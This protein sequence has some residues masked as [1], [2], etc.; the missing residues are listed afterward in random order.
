VDE[1]LL[2]VLLLVAVAEDAEPED[3]G[4]EDTLLIVL[5]VDVA[6]LLDVPLPP[7]GGGGGTTV[8]LLDPV[9]LFPAPDV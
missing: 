7:S 3:V 9:V 4:P 6:A 8:P 2:S 1:V 5:L